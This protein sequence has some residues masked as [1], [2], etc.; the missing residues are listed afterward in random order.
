MTWEYNLI[1][2][3]KQMLIPASFYTKKYPFIQFRL[4]Q[5]AT[6]IQVTE[7]VEEDENGELIKKQTQKFS[8]GN[9]IY[10][11]EKATNKS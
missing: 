2:V 1:D 8:K 7:Y 3:F 5:F 11:N 9:I 6:D 4:P 10:F